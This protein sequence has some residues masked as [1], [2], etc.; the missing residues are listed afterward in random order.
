MYGSSATVE[1]IAWS[2]DRI[3]STC[4]DAL[5]DKVREQLVG[6]SA[7]E[8]GKPL[9]LKIMLGIVMDVDDS[10]LRSLTQNLQT[11]RMKNV[12]GKTWERL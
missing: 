10:A 8:S 9:V 11:S 1:N 4:G 7:L 6:V 12:L 5:W 3:L 2:A